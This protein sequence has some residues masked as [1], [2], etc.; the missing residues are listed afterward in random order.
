MAVAI[1]GVNET[2]YAVSNNK[3]PGF[4]IHYAGSKVRSFDL[5]SIYAGFYVSLRQGAAA[6]P[7]D[8]TIT[9]TGLKAGSGKM[10]TQAVNFRT[11]AA[12]GIGLVSQQVQRYDISSAFQG[13]QSVAVTYQ[14][15]VLSAVTNGVAGV[16]IDNVGYVTHS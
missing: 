4:S 16:A 2:D 3:S 6:P 12:L 10:V 1:T 8:C 5:N 7:L 14:P 15:R 13:M 11:G 9:F